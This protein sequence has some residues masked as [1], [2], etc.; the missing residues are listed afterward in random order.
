MPKAPTVPA[1]TSSP[2]AESVKKDSG[3]DDDDQGKKRINIT[4]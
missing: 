3:D 1:D 2:A 4:V